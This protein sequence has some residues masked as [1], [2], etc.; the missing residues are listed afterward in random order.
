MAAF[1]K[2]ARVLLLGLGQ[3]VP[4]HVEIAGRQVFDGV[5]ALVEEARLLDLVDE[6]VGDGLA[7]LVVPGVGS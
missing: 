6:R 7:R 4:V 3:G 1:S 2:A 5:E